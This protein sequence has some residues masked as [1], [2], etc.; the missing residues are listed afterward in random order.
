MVVVHF[1]VDQEGGPVWPHQA[2]CT[3]LRGTLPSTAITGRHRIVRDHKGY[4]HVGRV[5]GGRQFYT[6]GIFPCRGG[7]HQ[8]RHHAVDDR[9]A[10][11][12]SHW[13]GQGL[14]GN[15]LVAQETLQQEMHDP[16]P[17][18]A[19]NTE[20]RRKVFFTV[21]WVKRAKIPHT[22]EV[23][24]DAQVDGGGESANGQENIEQTGLEVQVLH[25]AVNRSDH[26]THGDDAGGAS[27]LPIVGE[28]W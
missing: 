27:R 9:T 19:G 1:E 3:W 2:L 16:V 17:P 28:M 13:S 24:R 21:L 25:A 12:K 14:L 20:R 7:P 15:G 5:Q 8:Q 22:K 11:Y 4:K 10:P 18:K 23:A 26:T 6:T